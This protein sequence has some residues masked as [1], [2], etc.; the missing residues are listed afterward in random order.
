LF[1]V[2]WYVFFTSMLP[3]INSYE[4]K[5]NTEV[6]F[7][8]YTLCWLLSLSVV[9]LPIQTLSLSSFLVSLSLSV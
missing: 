9:F 6:S 4:T 3:L 2:L 5:M 1:S 8:N 7:V